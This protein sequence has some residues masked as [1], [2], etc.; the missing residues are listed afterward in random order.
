M[1]DQ[2]VMRAI[3]PR[4][5]R[6]LLGRHH[7][8]HGRP[9]MARPLAHNQPH[10]TGG[11]MHHNRLARLHFMRAPQQ[12][13]RRHALQHHRRPGGEIDAIGQLH[14]LV[15]GN[16]ALGRIGTDRPAGI[17]NPVAHRHLGH[18]RADRQHGAGRFHAQRGR[19]R[20]LVQP[21]A[22]ID[23]DI[24]QP[25]RAMLHQRLTR[26]R[27]GRGHILPTHHIG[28][29]MGVNSNRFGHVSGVRIGQ[30]KVG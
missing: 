28:A 24:V 20:G 2:H 9:Q 19:Q 30:S 7:T 8:D 23:V 10:P 15:R 17:G 11:G 16:A 26:C 13:L 3:G 21:G 29:A 22:E 6:L 25:H 4:Q 12:I 18:A 27:I 14:Q 5:V 1:A